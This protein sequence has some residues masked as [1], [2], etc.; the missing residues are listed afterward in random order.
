MRQKL[1]ILCH[2]HLRSVNKTHNLENGYGRDCITHYSNHVSQL[3]A[4]RVQSETL[5]ARR[6][7]ELLI[8]KSKIYYIKCFEC[9]RKNA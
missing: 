9:V 4:P 1:S 6:W 5:A 2:R 7:K 8:R 3:K